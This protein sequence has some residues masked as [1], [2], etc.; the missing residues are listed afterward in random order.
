MRSGSRS[1]RV[2]DDLVGYRAEIAQ[3][4]G[5]LTVQLGV[6]TDGAFV[7]LRAHASPQGRRLAD[8][9]ADVVGHRLRFSSHAEPDHADEEA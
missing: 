3:A 8:V 7:R 9:A 6:G 4:T 5:I 1:A 2:F